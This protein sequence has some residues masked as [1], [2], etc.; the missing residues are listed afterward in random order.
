MPADLVAGV[1][2]EVFM[3]E[4]AGSAAAR[5]DLAVEAGITEVVGVGLAV[6][7][8]EAMAAGITAVLAAAILAATAA[9]ADSAAVVRAA[10]VL[11]VEEPVN[12]AVAA[13][14]DAAI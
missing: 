2:A 14:L 11:V 10:M 9:V 12:S 4:A 6:A 1:E 8:L 7:G 13:S 5:V 3:A